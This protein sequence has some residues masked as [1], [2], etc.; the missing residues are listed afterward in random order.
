MYPI[1]NFKHARSGCAFFLVRLM[2]WLYI[3]TV[4]G[5]LY[6]GDTGDQQLEEINIIKS[7]KN[8][9]WNIFEGSTLVVNQTNINITG[10]HCYKL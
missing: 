5:A 2:F 8:Y 1:L 6:C 4:D 3:S 9:G 7:G 10:I